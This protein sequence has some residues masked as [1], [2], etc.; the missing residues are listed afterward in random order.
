MT[1]RKR[2]LDLAVNY[3][4]GHLY[5]RYLFPI[6]PGKKFPP[7]IKNNLE[8]ASCDPEQLRA[9]EEKWPGCNWG[10]AHRK[11]EV[12][13][14]DVDTNPAKGKV[15][16]KTYDGLDLAYGWPE[17]ETTVTPSGGF[18]K[19]YVGLPGQKIPM[20]L[21]ENGLGK[22]IDV[23]NYTL[24]AGCSF[25]DGTEYVGNGVE[26]VPCPQWVYDEI[27]KA[28]G[29]RTT[30]TDAGEI[31]VELDQQANIDLAIDFL[32][33]DAE[34]SIQGQ[35]GD[36]KLRAAAYYLKDLGISQ[37]LGAELL[38]EYFNP[39][40]E[41]AW[42]MADLIKKMEGAYKYANLSKVGGKTAEADFADD[43]PEP[44]PPPPTPAAR[45]ARREAERAAKMRADA[46]KA[47][48][49]L[50]PN[51]RERIWSKQEVI[52][53]W[54]YIKGLERF[55]LKEDSNVM[56]K[57]TTFDKAFAYIPT[58]KEGKSLSEFLLRQKKATIARFDDAVYRPGKPAA[59][60]GRY[61][62]MYVQP[63]VVAAEGDLSWWDDHLE[64]L[65]PDEVNRNH[66]LNWMAW[67]LQNL[68]K[69]PKHA[70][71]LQGTEQ[72]TGKSFIVEML[73]R[74]I[75]RRNTSNINQ[76]DLHG[77]FNGWAARSKLLIIE[78]LRAVDRNEVANKL[79]PLITQDIISVNEKNL[80][81]RDVEN[82]FGIFA[83]SNHDAAITLDQSDRRYLVITTPASPRYGKGSPASTEYYDRLYARLDADADVAAVAY[84]LQNRD[85]GAYNG[86]G[87]A[88]ATTAKETMIEA[89]LSDLEHFMIDM[90]DSFPLNGRIIAVDDVIQILPRRLESRSPRLHSTIKSILKARFRAE[91]IGQ[92]TLS[93]RTRPRLMVIN[94]SGL[95]NFEGWQSRVAKQ[96]E[97]DKARAGKNLALEEL[98][99]AASEFVEP[100][101]PEMQ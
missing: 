35:S 40:C 89:G 88:P 80:P 70:L 43:P 25:D 17:T 44:L 57:T 63:T 101:A 7:L 20:A 53:E 73:A 26:A 24:I 60:D 93:D 98:E 69:K 33:N 84:M 65:L 18:H 23:P 3:V 61:Y 77:D 19:I 86:A 91:E 76:T 68:G 11:S 22:D 8:D 96:Y 15:G 90:R 58:K 71:L 1:T 29:K 41:P 39:R 4:D 100:G 78:E 13:V 99:D 62:N 28:K 75:N 74:I 27:N 16:Q 31:V 95:R 94:G 85:I 48:A 21:G 51:Q 79:H 32:K 82:C 14:V 9:W 10:L 64:Y 45:K 87:A 92:F 36:D 83:M 59:I 47:S 38:N 72:G 37:G 49:S 66:L 42:D 50:P 12:M 56:W 30:L 6:A 34:P 52:D 54:V 81:R 5:R 55:A 46:R 2:T 67:F 97:E